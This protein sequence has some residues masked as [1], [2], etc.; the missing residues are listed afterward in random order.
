[1]MD[2]P[3][4]ALDAWARIVMGLNLLLFWVLLILGVA[5]LVRYL[6]RSGTHTHHGKAEDILAER[7]A[8]GEIDEQ[9]YRQRLA[10][11]RGGEPG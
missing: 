10:V 4:Q 1:M 11:L 8:R 5:L 2:L 6:G 7:F 9:E 3:D